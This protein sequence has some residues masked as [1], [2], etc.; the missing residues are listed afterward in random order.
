MRIKEYLMQ[1]VKV[2]YLIYI[3]IN[4]KKDF[5]FLISGKE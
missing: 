3:H 2:I 4:V 1:N 5:R